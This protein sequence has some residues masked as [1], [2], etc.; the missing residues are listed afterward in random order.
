VIGKCV[1]RSQG[2]KNVDVVYLQMGCN[3]TSVQKVSG[4]KGSVIIG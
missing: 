1:Q 3:G 4:A 2:C